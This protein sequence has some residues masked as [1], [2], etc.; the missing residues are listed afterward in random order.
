MKI[1]Y[2][3]KVINNNNLSQTDLKLKIERSRRKDLCFASKTF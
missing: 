3:V 1:I 2:K